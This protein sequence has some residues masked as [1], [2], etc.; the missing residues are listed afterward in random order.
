MFISFDIFSIHKSE[1][2]LFWTHIYFFCLLFQGQS[3]NRKRTVYSVCTEAELQ[4][5]KEEWAIIIE[6]EIGVPVICCEIKL[7]K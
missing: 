1:Y 7:D 5:C 4:S 3:G 6:E 2:A